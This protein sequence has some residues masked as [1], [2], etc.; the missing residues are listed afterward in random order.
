MPLLPASGLLGS[1]LKFIKDNFSLCLVT[2]IFFFTSVWICFATLDPDFGWHIRLGEIILATGISETDPFSYTMPSYPFVD[3]EWGTN[4]L[5]YFLYTNYPTILPILFALAATIAPLLTIPKAKKGYALPF[6]LFSISVLLQRV[7]VRPQVLGWFFFAVF[8]RLLFDRFLWNKYRWC[9]PFLIAMWANLHGSFPIVFVIFGIHLFFSTIQE[10]RFNLND[11]GVFLASFLAS[12]FTPYGLSNW[13]E[14]IL[15][16]GQSNLFRSTVIEWMPFYNSFD[17]GLLA[18]FTV[19]LSLILAFWKKIPYSHTVIMILL[20]SMAISALRHASLFVL[21]STTFI[22]T[23]LPLFINKIKKI[24][25]AKTRL[26]KVMK[27]FTLLGAAFS[28]LIV[29]A[30]VINKPL[31]EQNF[32]P[33]GSVSYLKQNSHVIKGKMLSPYGWGGYLIWN[34]PE[35]KVYIDGRMAGFFWDG[36]ESES[37]RIFLEYLKIERDEPGWEDAFD[38]HKPDVV[39][40]YAMDF[41]PTQATGLERYLIDLLQLNKEE[42]N[43]KTTDLAERLKEK[44]WKEVYSDQISRVLIPTK[45]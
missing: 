2:L 15:Q 32:Y 25:F 8:I 22:L 28:A 14:I 36:P 34:F 13:K 4:V 41:M 10:R 45:P 21:A 11:I 42:Y 40:W 20:A 29:I 12:L 44:G 30:I 27:I 5:M 38:R 33:Q 24:P 7:S 19:N 31:S 9:L 35:S 3:Y 39:I 23:Y 18:L 26:N 17:F 1:L 16:V 6:V 43:H 37:D